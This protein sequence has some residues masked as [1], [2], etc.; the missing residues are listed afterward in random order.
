MSEGA[1]RTKSV[2]LGPTICGAKKNEAFDF[3]ACGHFHKLN[4]DL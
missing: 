1:V 3:Y 2:G 4:E